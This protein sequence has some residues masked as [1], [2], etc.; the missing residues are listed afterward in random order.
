MWELDIFGKYRR[1]FEAARYDVQAAA[2]ARYGV[3]TSLIADVV[4]AYIDLR[5][6]QIRAGI[7]R[8]ASD[9]LRESLRIV[10]IRYERGITN[11]LDVELATR[12][13]DTLLGANRAAWTPK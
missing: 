4:R 1:E 2:A 3:L 5:G 10:N 13:L 8:S 7:L 6:L 11:E 9:V 12:E